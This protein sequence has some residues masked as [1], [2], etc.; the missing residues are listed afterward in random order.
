VLRNAGS[1]IT[2]WNLNGERFLPRL[3]E[4]RFKMPA[5]TATYVDYGNAAAIIARI[6]NGAQ[7]GCEAWAQIVLREAQDLVPVRTGELRDSGHIEVVASR[8]TVDVSVV[9]DSPHA[10][11][12]ELGTG[13]RGAASPGAGP[14][15]YNPN[16]PGMPARPYIRS[17]FDANSDSAETII[18]LFVQGAL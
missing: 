1:V 17:A 4:K 9:F 14:G 10:V 2:E 7:E 13:R 3:E 6:A 11:Y 18:D 12:V 8:D 5:S 15:P 16:W